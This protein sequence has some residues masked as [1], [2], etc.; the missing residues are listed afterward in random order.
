MS[1]DTFE[2]KK[3]Q[4]KFKIRTLSMY[5]AGKNG[6]TREWV[7]AGKG[8][9]KVESPSPFGATGAT[10]QVEAYISL[11]SIWGVPR[12]MGRYCS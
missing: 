1:D 3:T 7:A 11:T 8:N 4:P 12:L 2:A 9:F 5:A 10:R 6:Y